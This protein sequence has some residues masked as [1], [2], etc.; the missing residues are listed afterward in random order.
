MFYWKSA[1][2][3]STGP[4]IWVLLFLAIIL[5]N[6]LGGQQHTYHNPKPFRVRANI[7][8]LYL[9]QLKCIHIYI[10]R[11]HIWRNGLTF[12]LLYISTFIVYPFLW[13]IIHLGFSITSRCSHPDSYSKLR[14]FRCEEPINIEHKTNAHFNGVQSWTIRYHIENK[15]HASSLDAARVLHSKLFSN[16]QFLFSSMNDLAS[17]LWFTSSPAFHV[18]KPPAVV[19]YIF[20]T[21]GTLDVL[22]QC[23]LPFDIC[24]SHALWREVICQLPVRDCH[25]HN[26]NEE[27]CYSPSPLQLNIQVFQIL[28]VAFLNLQS[29]YQIKF[30]FS[31]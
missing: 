14:S 22:S 30:S 28:I 23:Q 15:Q 10:R 13:F 6:F 4:Y 27:K 29:T 11:I 20:Y 8:S 9:T 3:I 18:W 5:F 16:N 1:V 17:S 7:A 12:E 26:H 31:T 25:W 19:K 2:L 24:C 21:T